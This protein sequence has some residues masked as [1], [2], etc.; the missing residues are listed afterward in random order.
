MLAAFIHRWSQGRN[1]NA[2]PG[3]R[4]YCPG[5]VS[6]IA[7]P[8]KTVL[9]QLVLVQPGFGMILTM[10]RNTVICEVLD[11]VLR[12]KLLARVSILPRVLV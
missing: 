2:L 10:L 1:T 4:V 7:G 8:M 3:S 6:H 5:L 11:S 9:V 12:S